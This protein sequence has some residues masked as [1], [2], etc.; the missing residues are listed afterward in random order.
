[1]KE[2]K[3]FQTESKELLNLMVNSIYSNN[4]IFLRELISNASDA[5]D[6]YKFTALKS[7]GKLEQRDYQIFISSDKDA[8]TLTIKDNGIGMSKED[9]ENNLGT[10]ARSGSKDFVAK[11]KEAKESENMNI[12]GQ[13]GVGFYSAFMV[14]SKIEVLTKKANEQAYLFTS[15][16]VDTYTIEDAESSEEGT[17]ITLYLKED[18]EDEKYSRFLEQ[19]EIQELVRKYSDYIR[20]PIK[21]NVK[22]TKPKLDEEG[23]EIEGQT[24]EVIEERTL[25]S[26]VP[27]WKKNKKDVTDEELASFYKDKFGE[28]ED[29][30]TSLFINVDGMISYNAL[31]FIPS[32]A[33][34]NLYSE[35]YEKGLDLYAKGV[36]IKEKC[37]E[38]VPDYLKFIKGL[39]DSDDFSLNISREILQNSPMLR[40]IQDNIESK[41]I[42]KLKDIKNDNFDKYLEF[43]KI[44]GDNLKYGIYSSYGSKTELLKDLILFNSLN[45]EKMISLK[46]YKDSIKEDQK[47]IYYA[48]GK[49]L[50]SIKLLPQIEKFKKDGIDVLLLDHN[51]DEFA[52]QMMREYDGLSFKSI[53]EENKQEL[54]EEEKSKIDQLVIDNKRLIDDLNEALKGK[55]DEVSFSTRLVESPVCIT[56]KDGLSLNMEH[57][58]NEEQQAASIDESERVKA[59][60]VLEINPDH[61]LFKAI[62]SLND[63]EKI[64]K[65]GSL[66]YE[67]AMMLEGYD[68]KDKNEFVK[69]LN[70]LMIEA[71]N[72]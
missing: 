28:W 71:L 22:T 66:L 15:D 30:F 42:N 64:K 63:D 24:E 12:I 44:Y 29:P 39:V 53:S 51:I 61:Q 1:M 17:S 34:Y 36:F 19:Y 54:N 27:L 16:G 69:T 25:N 70:E 26:M 56:T 14:A 43:Y 11:F 40:R 60:K 8:R 50:A 7:E 10:I 38:L 62:A 21:M 65:Y 20:Y 47:V 68:V 58:L 41:V 57:V 49:S 67:E 9:L 45:S 46:D 2:T 37:K 23:K 3:E 31:I 35:N 5:I 33:P 72:K 13:F 59:R 6:K 52:L 48:T 18:T 55:V 4:E 32:H